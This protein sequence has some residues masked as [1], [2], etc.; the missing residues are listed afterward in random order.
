MFRDILAVQVLFTLVWLSAKKDFEQACAP[1]I[2]E[3]NGTVKTG[4][5]EK[6]LN[7]ICSVGTLNG[8]LI[9]DVPWMSSNS[10]QIVIIW[11]SL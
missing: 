4:P 10:V 11:C 5:R 8:W 2:Y 3:R 9:G 7:N 1:P 6:H